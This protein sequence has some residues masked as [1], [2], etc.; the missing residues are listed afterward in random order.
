MRVA[1]S[2]FLG[3][4]VML[5]GVAEAMTPR[6]AGSSIL[7]RLCEA[8]GGTYYPDLR[9]GGYSCYYPDGSMLTCSGDGYC[10]KVPARAVTTTSGMVSR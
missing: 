8:G 2:V 9:G 7:R 3:A 1:A 6:P 5:T 10:I 4:S